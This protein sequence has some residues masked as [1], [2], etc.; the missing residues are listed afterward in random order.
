MT[1]SLPVHPAIPAFT[2]GYRARKMDEEAIRAWIMKTKKTRRLHNI[3]KWLNA[4]IAGAEAALIDLKPIKTQPNVKLARQNAQAHL[5]WATA[6][7]AELLRMY[8]NARSQYRP[9]HRP[10]RPNR[11]RVGLLG[12]AVQVF[13]DRKPVDED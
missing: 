6:T 12:R 2:V 9:Q 4:E 1:G 5:D 13:K 8:P 3:R 11:V 7:K 10:R